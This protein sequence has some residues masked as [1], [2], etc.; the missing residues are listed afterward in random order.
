MKR[1]KSKVTLAALDLA[2][3]QYEEKKEVLSNS[4]AMRILTL[5][6]GLKSGENMLEVFEKDSE[7]SFEKNK[8]LLAVAKEL[9]KEFNKLEITTEKNSMF[10]LYLRTFI[11][12]YKE[13]YQTNKRNEG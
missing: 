6:Q 10:D 4:A 7:K 9:V 13:L 5:Y 12:R 8:N 2:E 3:N 1:Q 11:G